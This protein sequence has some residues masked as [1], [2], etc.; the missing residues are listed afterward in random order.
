[1][2]SKDII[3]SYRL[4]LQ[5]IVNFKQASSGKGVPFDL[6][7]LDLYDRIKQGKKLL[8]TI[9]TESNSPAYEYYL[10]FNSL[11]DRI[12]TCENWQP[13]FQ[14]KKNLLKSSQ[15]WFTKLRGALMLGSIQE[16]NDPLAPLSKNYR[17]TEEEA[18][19]IPVNIEKFLDDI[20][21]EL[22]SCKKMDKLKILN[23]LKNQT[24]K[25]KEDL[26]LPLFV[27]TIA[28][29]L[30]T[31][32]PFRTNNCLETFFR[33]VKSI[34]RRNTGRSAV[35]NEFASIGDLLPYYVYMKDHKTFKHFF[36]NED[37]LIEEFSLITRTKWNDAENVLEFERKS[38]I[39]TENHNDMIDQI[40][41]SNGLM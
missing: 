10:A 30:N 33:L 29:Q 12:H 40:A 35:T 8:D 32:I 19:A 23:R 14:Q 22:S 18:K 34:I 20:D 5:W 17:L 6:P 9:F 7:Y 26:K 21:V 25:Y 11:V 13:D 1:M 2:E 27:L 15:K 39:R 41:K 37:K 24:L 31:I 36:E 28:G 4:V 16:N 3:K 38:P